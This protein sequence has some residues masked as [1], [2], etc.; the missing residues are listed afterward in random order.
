[1]PFDPITALVGSWN[2]PLLTAFSQIIDNDAFFAF[3][4]LFAAFMA[5]RG[6]K[7]KWL[8]LTLGLVFLMGLSVKALAHEPRPCLEAASK[9][10]CP[11]GFSFPSDHAAVAF[12]LA[13][14]LREK[15][16]KWL[17][18]IFAA[19]VAFSRVYLGVHTLWDVLGGAVLGIAICLLAETIWN[20]ENHK[21]SAGG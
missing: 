11:D 4:V 12:A 14:A 16:G 17:Y 13:T 8:F 19:L 15:P 10:P 7:R 5:E 18:A 1:M 9:I 21:F 20:V 6:G 2:V 3:V